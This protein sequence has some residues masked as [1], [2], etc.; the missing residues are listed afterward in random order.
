MSWTR[1]CM[2]AVGVSL[3]VGGIF[4]MTKYRDEVRLSSASCH[5]RVAFM[6]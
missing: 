6:R 1:L 5:R 4:I 3:I 2:T